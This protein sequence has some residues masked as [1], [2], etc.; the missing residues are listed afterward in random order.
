MTCFGREGEE[1]EEWNEKMFWCGCC[2]APDL[3]TNAAKADRVH[4]DR[5]NITKAKL[6]KGKLAGTLA[7]ECVLEREKKVQMTRRSW[8][9]NE[10]SLSGRN[11]I[12]KRSIGSEKWMVGYVCTPIFS[13]NVADIIPVL[14][15]QFMIPNEKSLTLFRNKNHLQ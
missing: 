11:L 9:R 10:E 6:R 1:R 13:N 4:Q 14:S 3:R 8:W 7:F 5:G 2:C 15:S 12:E